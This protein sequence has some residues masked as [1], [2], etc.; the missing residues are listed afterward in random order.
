MLPDMVNI[1][2]EVV[3]QISNFWNWFNKFISVKM[4]PWICTSEQKANWKKICT[5]HT[6]WS[7][8]KLSSKLLNETSIDVM[9]N[10]NF[11][12]EEES[13]SKQDQFKVMLIVFFYEKCVLLKEWVLKC[14]YKLRERVR[15]KRL[16]RW[17]DGFIQHQSMSQLLTHDSL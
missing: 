11:S 8:C 13:S 10:P 3:K 5:A 2:K 7:R 6:R 17:A 12:K 16:E 9:E 15:I 1:K 14:G 4:L